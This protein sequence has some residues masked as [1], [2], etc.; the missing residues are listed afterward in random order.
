V[1]GADEKQ[2]RATLL[3]PILLAARKSC[4]GLGNGYL[5]KGDHTFQFAFTSFDGDWKSH[6]RFGNE[7]NSPFPSAAVPPAVAGPALPPFFS[8]CRASEPNYVVSDIKIADDHRGII[9]RGYEM[10]G[11]NSQ[12][13]LKFPLQVERANA[14]DLI[15]EDDSEAV[16]MHGGQLQFRAKHFAIDTFRIIG[17][18]NVQSAPP[19]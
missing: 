6:Y 12:V 5:Q 14:T 1:D 4:H 3:Q 9:V 13:T 15:E 2:D 7:V 19:N 11:L 10:T 17:K 8:L 16:D 18:C